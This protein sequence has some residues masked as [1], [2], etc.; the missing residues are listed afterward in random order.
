MPTIVPIVEGH[1]EVP[2][3]RPLI[4]R[5]LAHAESPVPIEVARPI[6]KP[7]SK[8]VREGELERAVQLASRQCGPDGLV[9][10]MIDA[11]D[12]CAARLGPEL[13]QRSRRVTPFR[14]SV[15]LPVCE[16]EAWLLA[17]ARSIAGQRGLP[18]DLEP[19]DDPEGLRDAKGWITSRLPN[20]DIYKETL[21]QVALTSS[22][23]VDA[24]LEARSFRKLYGELTE[25][26][27]EMD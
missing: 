17:S 21:D 10:V 5:I 18:T 7:R 27:D 20:G 11:D 22:L 9:L 23:D 26:L 2:S 19:P 8:L 6:R 25:Y 14:V 16:Y 12:D 3:V 13:E 4:Y 15:V 24:A 1:G